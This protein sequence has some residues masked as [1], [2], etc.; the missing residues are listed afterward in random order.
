MTGANCFQL[1][2]SLNRTSISESTAA[3]CTMCADHMYTVFT[4][5]R[6]Y[7]KFKVKGAERLF[8]FTV[9]MISKI[10]IWNTKLEIWQSL[11]ERRR[12]LAYTSHSSI[13]SPTFHNSP[14]VASSWV[15][16]NKADFQIMAPCVP[17][18]WPASTSTQPN[19][20]A[21]QLLADCMCQT[22]F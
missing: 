12:R 8:S 11:W 6:S 18:V 7:L 20:T 19:T 22:L 5:S 16:G 9:H 1:H 14:P 4:A 17:V 3:V 2:H 10:H 21:L 13:L 15:F